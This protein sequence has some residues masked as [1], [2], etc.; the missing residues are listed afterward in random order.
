MHKL[1]AWITP[2]TR[3]WLYG[4]SMAVIPLLIT[5]G[6]LTEGVAKDIALIVAALLGF[7]TNGV[8][9]A[10]VT[11]PSAVKPEDARG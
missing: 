11:V 2:E 7:T 1:V 9:K 8:A 10:N 3:N 5:L 4:V 6:V